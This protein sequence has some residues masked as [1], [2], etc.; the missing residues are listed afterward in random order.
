M[1]VLL[2][3]L[4][5]GPGVGVGEGVVSTLLTRDLQR[6]VAATLGTESLGNW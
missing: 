2:P 6:A 4:L 5:G 1:V 3:L